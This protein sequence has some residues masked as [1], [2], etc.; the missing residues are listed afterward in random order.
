MTLIL[1]KRYSS[2]IIPVFSLMLFWEH[3]RL[4][5]MF[6]SLE[7]YY[8]ITFLLSQNH[9]LKVNFWKMQFIKNGDLN[10]IRVGMLKNSEWKVHYHYAD[11]RVDICPNEILND[12]SRVEMNNLSR[13]VS[14]RSLLA[15]CF[16]LCNFLPFCWFPLFLPGL[17]IDFGLLVSSFSRDISSSGFSN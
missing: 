13:N 12:S 3:F 4:W 5:S 16:H 15:F 2:P 14:N 6:I 8:R 10:R 1:F 7:K 17:K 9:F 11:S